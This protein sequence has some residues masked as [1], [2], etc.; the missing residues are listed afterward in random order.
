MIEFQA[1]RQTLATTQH[2]P[3]QS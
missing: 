2:T 3:Y 1:I